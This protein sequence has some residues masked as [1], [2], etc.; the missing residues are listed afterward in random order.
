MSPSVMSRTRVSDSQRHESLTLPPSFLYPDPP[1]L[2]K[3]HPDQGGNR[4]GREYFS[5]YVLILSREI[6]TTKCHKVAIQ[7]A[8]IYANM[9]LDNQGLEGEPSTNKAT[10]SRMYDV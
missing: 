8:D 10:N 6:S 3:N 9:F 7:Q 2:I 4:S 5:T 1:S